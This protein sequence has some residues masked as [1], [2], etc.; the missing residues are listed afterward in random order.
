MIR[1]HKGTQ[2]RGMI[3]A[4]DDDGNAV[5]IGCPDGFFEGLD[6]GT[7]FDGFAFMNAVT[8]FLEVSTALL[9]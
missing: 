4:T 6:P 7:V 5:Q 9:L 1:F 8:G 3:S 2:I